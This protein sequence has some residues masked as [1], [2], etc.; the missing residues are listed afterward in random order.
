MRKYF[1]TI[2]KKKNNLS[3]LPYTYKQL[4]CFSYK[5]SQ[6]WSFSLKWIGLSAAISELY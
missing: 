5:L 4:H 1:K 2:M 3:L 6:P